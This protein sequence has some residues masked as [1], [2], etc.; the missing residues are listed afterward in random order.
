MPY[1]DYEF[2]V[3]T[4][5]GRT[6]AQED[7]PRLA[8]R[9]SDYIDR[10]TLSRAAD[11]IDLH[12][13]LKKACC[14]VAEQMQREESGGAIASQTVGK[15]TKNYVTESTTAAKRIY[16]AMDFYLGQTGLLVRWV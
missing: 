9:A 6:I 4:Y 14:A 16:D 15:W 2:Y 3:G 12:G 5:L 11:Y 8:L 13:L 7:F 1:A 10:Q